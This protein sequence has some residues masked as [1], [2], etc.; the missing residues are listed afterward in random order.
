MR[1]VSIAKYLYF[2][3]GILLLSSCLKE[4]EYVASKEQERRQSAVDEFRLHF[5]A[6][7]D[8]DRLRSLS[9]AEGEQPLLF[10][11]LQPM[12][13]HGKLDKYSLDLESVE[14]PLKADEL[15][16]AIPQT[17]SPEDIDKYQR[18]VFSLSLLKEYNPHTK[19]KQEFFVCFLP[20]KGQLEKGLPRNYRLATLPKDYEGEII[21]FSLDLKPL[22]RYRIGNGQIEEKYI[23]TKAKNSLRAW[24]RVDYC[25]WVLNDTSWYVYMEGSPEDAVYHPRI[26]F[27]VD[28]IPRYEWIS[29]DFLEVVER[30]KAN[31]TNVDSQPTG[32]GGS[33]SGGST[34][35]EDKYKPK[36]DRGLS[37]IISG[38][39]LEGF[40][41][42]DIEALNAA[43][44]KMLEHPIY[45]RIDEL[46]KG[47]GKKLKKMILAGKHGFG[48]A[49]VLSN[50]TFKFYTRENINEFRLSHEW[51]HMA[52]MA[53]HKGV[54]DRNGKKTYGYMEFEGWLLRDIIKKVDKN[55]PM[56]NTREPLAIRVSN[57][58][59]A[60]YWVETLHEDY[61][62]FLDSITGNG[63][64][65]PR[66]KISVVEFKKLAKLFLKYNTSYNFSDHPTDTEY[67]PTLL[68]EIFDVK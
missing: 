12:W 29:D 63:T 31:G 56:V 39:R 33:S 62:K 48:S 42:K 40:E 36:I 57:L 2:L 8:E 67:A 24:V 35:I 10:K 53:K 30:I 9:S 6:S 37:L 22:Y 58:D 54:L 21:L 20:S 68:E 3:L 23:A 44:Q 41:D 50:W 14:V 59:K 5:D 4:E 66:G 34:T 16:L 51:I 27:E 26:K 32:G 43:Y 38:D 13:E 49:T 7:Y 17:L 64:H 15:Y 60:G 1:I 55:S 52:Q 11:G 45:K 25:F 61:G 18:K 19:F 46:I 65:Y 28:C 47:S